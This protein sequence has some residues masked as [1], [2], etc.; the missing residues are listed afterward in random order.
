MEIEEGQFRRRILLP[1]HV[2]AEKITARFREGLLRIQVP[3]QGRRR[4]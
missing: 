4:G 1:E 3:K 2:D